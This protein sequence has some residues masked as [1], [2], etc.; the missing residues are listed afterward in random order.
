[1]RAKSRRCGRLISFQFGAG[2]VGATVPSH[3]ADTFRG[4]GW[5][6]E[7]ISLSTNYVLWRLHFSRVLTCPSEYQYIEGAY[8]VCSSGA[9]LKGNPVRVRNCP[10][11]VSRNERSVEK[12]WFSHELGSWS[13]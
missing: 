1:M 13:K 3:S 10:A 4:G 8:G 9:D 11:A 7:P 12:H 6:E 5:R 2:L